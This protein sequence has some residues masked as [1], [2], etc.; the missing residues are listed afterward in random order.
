MLLL[1]EE[2]EVVARSSSL[3]RGAEEVGKSAPWVEVL[4]ERLIDRLID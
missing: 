2:E 3:A 4:Q 1:E